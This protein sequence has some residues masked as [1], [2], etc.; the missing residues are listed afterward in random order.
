VIVGILVM[1][2]YFT[3]LGNRFFSAIT[4]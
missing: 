3:V 1:T 4:K 2:N